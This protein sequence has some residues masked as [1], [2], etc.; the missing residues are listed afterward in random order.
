MQERAK[1]V[2]SIGKECAKRVKSLVKERTKRVESTAIQWMFPYPDRP[3]SG[4]T[5]RYP[6]NIFKGVAWVYPYPDR[7]L[8]RQN[9]E[10]IAFKLY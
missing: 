4:Q 10:I 3:L 1:R 2:A 6:D 8:S 9:L 5:L 7:R